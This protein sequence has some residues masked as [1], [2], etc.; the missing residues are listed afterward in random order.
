MQLLRICNLML[1][2]KETD[3]PSYIAE[4]YSVIPLG[5]RSGLIEWVEGATP[6]FQVYRKWQIRQAVE[7]TSNQKMNE[8]ERPSALFFKKLKAAFQ[9]NVNSWCFLLNFTKASLFILMPFL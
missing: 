1:L 3:W 5:S 2:T 7:N 8:V 6:I 9:A 4:N